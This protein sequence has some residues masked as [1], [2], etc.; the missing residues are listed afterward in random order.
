MISIIIPTYNRADVLS[1]AV[2]SVLRQSVTDWELI[3]VDDGSKDSTDDLV[4]KY[5]EDSRVRYIKHAKN[6]GQNAA[7]NTGIASARGEY[8]AFLDSDDEWLPLM[9]EKQLD[10]FNSKPNIGCSYTWAGTIGSNGNLV[11]VYRFVLE[12][13]I[14]K[15]A[16]AQGYVSHMITVMVK[17]S[18]FEVIGPFDVEFKVCQDDEI[19]MRLAK[20]F[21]F[22]LI[23]EPL[24][25]IYTDG[26]EQT[27]R[28]RINY[29]NGH[30][31]LLQ[32]F[33]VDIQEL[34]GDNVYATLQFNCAYLLLLA[35]DIP[36][37][38]KLGTASLRLSFKLKTAI[39]LILSFIPPL[40]FILDKLRRKII[41]VSSKVSFLHFDKL[42][43]RKLK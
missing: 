14:Y 4:K 30:L 35:N 19:C 11:P 41:V 24:A 16:L 15:Q 13:S 5:L 26:G 32:K 3:I 2:D 23:S 42:F 27:I 8:C 18:C 10:N 40:F 1:R 28:S 22:G 17:S 9:L 25:I 43:T 31:K 37:C 29:A 39:L 20:H 36:N 6:S 34:C 33:R 12:G 7:L 21:D 38:R